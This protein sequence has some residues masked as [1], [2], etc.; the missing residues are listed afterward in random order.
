ME[1]QICAFIILLF[2]CLL[3]FL[4]RNN[5]FPYY[6]TAFA[7]QNKDTIKESNNS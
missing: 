4:L 3:L 5:G 1:K 2:V 7:T 6:T